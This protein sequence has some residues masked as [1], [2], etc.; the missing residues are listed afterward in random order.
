MKDYVLLKQKKINKWTTAFEPRFYTI[1][2]IQGS[3]ITIRRIK[4]R[5]ELCRDASQLKP[6]NSLLGQRSTQSVGKEEEESTCDEE[7]DDG[8]AD[9]DVEENDRMAN[10]GVEQARPPEEQ[11]VANEGINRRGRERRLPAR[12]RDYILS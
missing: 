7:T 11:G 6:A 1:T 9:S 5:R 8:T 12:L 2:K 10:G 3:S 4:D